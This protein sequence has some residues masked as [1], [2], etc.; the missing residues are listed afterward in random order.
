MQFKRKFVHL[1]IPR[2]LIQNVAQI[3]KEKKNMHGKLHDMN[4]KKWKSKVVSLVKSIEVS[5]LHAYVL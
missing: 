1:E 4:D 5:Q 3:N 2:E